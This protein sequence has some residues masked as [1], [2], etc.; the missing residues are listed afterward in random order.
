MHSMLCQKKFKENVAGS[1]HTYLPLFQHKNILGKSLEQKE[2]QIGE[3]KWW[4][5]KQ[6]INLL[7]TLC[8]IDHV[9]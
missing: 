1:H 3:H 6:I 8:F 5:R 7:P 9:T 2:K 4:E